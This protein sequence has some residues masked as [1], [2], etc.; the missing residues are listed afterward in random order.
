MLL[1]LNRKREI[2]WE[3]EKRGRL[4]ENSRRWEALSR[5]RL[6]PRRL[7]QPHQEVD[8]SAWR[9]SENILLPLPNDLTRLIYLTSIRD[10]NSGFYRHPTLSRQFDASVAHR[11]FEVWHQQVFA[12]MLANPISKYVEQLEG[13]IAYS[14]AER[15]LFIKSW[16]LLE[17]YKA[18]IP[19]QVPKRVSEVFFLNVK[20]ALAIL[21]H[22]SHRSN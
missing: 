3:G 8:E 7:E 20:T 5:N 18:A 15:D 10:Y 19:L 9:E 16:T 1:K 12:R 4:R 6:E 11:V 17:A 13:Y 21:N 2:I 22:L 14:R